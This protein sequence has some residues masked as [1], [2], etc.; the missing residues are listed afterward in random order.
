[1]S[2]SAPKVL[3]T[4]CARGGSKGMPR[5]NVMD[6]MGKPLI[7]YT[8]DCAR[9]CSAIGHFVVSTDSDEIAEVV[10]SLGVAVPFR[11]PADL[12]SDSA[13]KIG[14]IRHATAYVEEHEGFRPEIIV[15]LDISVPLRT[16]DDVTGLVQ[17]MI[18][19]DDLDAA[20]TIYEPDRN[21][22][23]TM[24]EPDG[25]LIQ[26]SKKPAKG[27]VRR[28]DVPPV[29]GVSGSGFAYRRTSLEM[30]EHLYAGAWGGYLIPRE[31][32]IEVDNEV[33]L[34]FVEIMMSRIATEATA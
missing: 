29:Y 16:P 28:Q 23:Y 7:S 25:H 32:A 22:Y 4:I 11:R 8:L 17:V 26:L 3:A 9:Q 6:L 15:D 19:H 31:R 14:A 21:P 10:E 12:A 13:A 33:D 24:V 1:M 18:A 30:I 5:K 2:D 27:I 20:V 34:R